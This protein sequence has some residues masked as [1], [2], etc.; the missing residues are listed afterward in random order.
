MNDSWHTLF[1]EI[2]GSKIIYPHPNC[3]A[4]TKIFNLSSSPYLIV[5]A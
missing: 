4:I 2:P 5:Y 3:V 1:H